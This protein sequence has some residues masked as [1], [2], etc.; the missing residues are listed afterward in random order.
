MGKPTNGI[1]MRH[2]NPLRAIIQDALYKPRPRLSRD[3]DDGR[4][5]GI[6]PRDAQVAYGLEGER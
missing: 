4:K 3:T 2:N 5:I 6:H 1:N